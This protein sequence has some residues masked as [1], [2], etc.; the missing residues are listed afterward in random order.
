MSGNLKANWLDASEKE[1]EFF[2]KVVREAIE[3]SVKEKERL[4]LEV[5]G[6]YGIV[7]PKSINSITKTPITRV[8]ILQSVLQ[9]HGILVYFDY[10]VETKKEYLRVYKLVEEVEI[11][12]E[13]K[14]VTNKSDKEELS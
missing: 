13:I 14:T 11:E 12:V 2:D 4:L 3:A 5:F 1:K 7:L 6:K 10:D 8:N 9:K